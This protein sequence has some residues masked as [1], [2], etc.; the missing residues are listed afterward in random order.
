VRA[1][2]RV[3]R[4]LGMRAKGV[5]LVP[6]AARPVGPWFDATNTTSLQRVANR[7]IIVH[8]LEALAAAGARETLILASPKVSDQIMASVGSGSAPTSSVSCLEEERSDPAG[9][10]QMLAEFAQD[11]PLLVHRADGLVT[12]P[13]AP[14]VELLTA[15]DADIVLLMTHG[16][17]N[18]ERIGADAKRALGVAELDPANPAL[19]MAGVCV[20]SSR[21]IDRI[22]SSVL[23]RTPAGLELG[24]IAEAIL[25]NE[26]S[27]PQVGLVREWHAFS[28][29]ARDLLDMNRAVLDALDYDT[30]TPPGDSES[31]FEGRVMID[32]SASVTSSVIC[33][34]AI[35]G[36]GAYIADSYIG[37]HT[38]IGEQVRVEGSEIERSIVLA[39]ASVLHVS[40][41]LVASIVGRDARVFRDFSVPRA[42]RLQV[43]DG[44][45]VALC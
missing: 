45:E 35:V 29:G 17:R 41:R 12:Q 3:N 32:P 43:G 31:S 1:Q 23:K 11:G 28:G 6:P 22:G 27:H 38:S 42:L 37:P 8:V 44:N 19:A 26:K 20:L 18:A 10:L 16:A 24:A 5:I 21:A 25:E 39:G 15:N 33:G 9:A 40:S 34:P 4:C 14:F 2:A 13:L 7:P 30:G 36:P